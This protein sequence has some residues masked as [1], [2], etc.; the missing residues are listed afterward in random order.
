MATPK[1]ARLQNAVTLCSASLR[2]AYATAFLDARAAL[3]P[4]NNLDDASVS[5]S[6]AC[7][8][9]SATLEYAAMLPS[10]HLPR[11]PCIAQRRTSVANQ[12]RAVADGGPGE[13]W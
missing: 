7:S 2:V 1:V 8:L 4:A 12:L 10:L 11:H 5:I 6:H 13:S 9:R 3:D